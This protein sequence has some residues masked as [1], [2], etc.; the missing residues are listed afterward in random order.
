M[1][2]INMALVN[3]GGVT[4]YLS[5]IANNIVRIYSR[6]VSLYG[7]NYLIV[8][9]T[10]PMNNILP[11]KFTHEYTINLKIKHQL[12]FPCYIYLQFFVAFVVISHH[13]CHVR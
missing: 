10:F 4:K 13:K 5:T 3:L 1:S 11:F 12:S 6:N 8:D 9:G 7:N 2:L